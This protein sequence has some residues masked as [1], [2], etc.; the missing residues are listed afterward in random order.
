MKTNPKWY[1]AEKQIG[2]D[3][4]ESEIASEYDFEHQQ[5][6]DFKKE[7]EDMVEKLI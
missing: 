5:F 2:V 7:A 4:S 6:R 1:F 3:Y